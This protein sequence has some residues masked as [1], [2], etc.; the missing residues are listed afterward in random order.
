MASLVKVKNI[1]K[2]VF[3][4]KKD[5]VHVPIFPHH[6]VIVDND[7][8]LQQ[9]ISNG[10]AEIEEYVINRQPV[11][12]VP[13]VEEPVTPPAVEVSPEPVVIKEDDLITIGSAPVI[14]T[15][16]KL[17]E[18]PVSIENKDDLIGKA[19]DLGLSEENDL[20]G[21]TKPE[22]EVLINQ[23]EEDKI[24]IPSGDVVVDN[25]ELPTET[26]AVEE[27]VKRTRR[28]SK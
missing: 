28:S 13:L 24:E 15:V 8:S 7:A 1:G 27:P 19:V 20:V 10:L 25:V 22:L 2:V 18:P 26:P 4:A 6:S 16:E 9:N 12:T 23:A 11:A 5:G 14:D 21:M 17:P 3:Y